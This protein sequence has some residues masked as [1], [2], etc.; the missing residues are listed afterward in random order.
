MEN[1]SVYRGGIPTKPDVKKLLE[2]FPVSTLTVGR[3]ITYEEISLVIGEPPRTSRFR[4]VTN[5]WRKEVEQTTNII[6]GTHKGQALVILSDSGKLCLASDKLTSAT[7]MA[8]KATIVA[9][10]IEVK[11]LSDAE[12]EALTKIQKRAAFF[13]INEA[14]KRP[15]A[16]P[17]I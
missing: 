17:E 14:F 6:M 8:A 13:A 5:K 16:I 11:N 12:R 9:A 2:K 15:Q 1:V 10:K 7:K 3:V 4:T